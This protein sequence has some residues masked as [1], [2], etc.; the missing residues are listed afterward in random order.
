MKEWIL[1]VPALCIALAPGVA[2]A[3]LVEAF[4][5]TGGGSNWNV[6]VLDAGTPSP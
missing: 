2:P 3:E 5:F 6:T 4:D 1:M